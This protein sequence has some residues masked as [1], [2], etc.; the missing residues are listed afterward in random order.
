MPDSIV[1]VGV[2]VFLGQP[3]SHSN[4]R[5]CNLCRQPV[6]IHSLDQQSFT[7]IALGGSIEISDPLDFPKFM[8]SGDETIY[9]MSPE[10][11]I[12]P[13]GREVSGLESVRRGT[14]GWRPTN[15]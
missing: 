12:V 2:R 10:L 11:Q 8:G 1:N 14:L 4:I 3:L 6:K 5:L 9:R 15:S 13:S 7:G